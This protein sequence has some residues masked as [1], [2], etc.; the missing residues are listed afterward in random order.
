MPIV[1]SIA[2]HD[3]VKATLKYI[4]NPEKTE[5]LF[6]CNSLNCFTNAEDAYLNMKYIYENYT[7]HKFNEPLPAVGKR[8]VKAIHY[9]QSFKPD[10]N[11]T[12][13][14]VHR[15]GCAFIRKAFG[16][17]VQAVIATHV[18]K[19][20]Y[21]NHVLICTYG[22]DGHKFNDNYTTRRAI[23]EH[24]DRV[25]LAFGVPYI[26]PKH[27]RGMSYGEWLHHKRGTSWKEK[28]R[29]E[30]DT[31]VMT[32]KN[33]DELAATLEQRGYAIRYGERPAIKAPGQ[34]RFVCFKTLGDD[35]TIANINTRILWRDD[36]GNASREDAYN[37]GQVLT[38]CFAG[39]IA[40][41]AK[42]IVE[43]KKREVKRDEELPY[44]PH[45]DR[46][47]FQLGAQLAL[48]NKLNI[49]SIGEL[50]AKMKEAQTA[51]DSAV[52]EFNAISE[53]YHRLDDLLIQYD[54]YCALEN[55]P[56]KSLA[57]KMKLQ[58]AKQS[59][60]RHGIKT[61][62]DAR[63]LELQKQDYDNRIAELKEKMQTNTNLLSAY[64]EIIDTYNGISKGDYITHLMKSE[65]E[66]ETERR[67]SAQERSVPKHDTSAP[68]PIV[69]D[70]APKPKQQ[71]SV[72]EKSEPK[73]DES[74]Q[75]S[76]VP[77]KSRGRG[78]GRG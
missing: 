31:L 64:R 53:E 7:H 72:Q 40:Q 13:E 63:K 39:I 27:K 50:E 52:K 58:L 2:I 6:L 65:E 9:I 34:Q 55:K 37:K 12:P 74:S 4:L 36:L 71:E 20:H 66:L 23:R 59:L 5:G 22:I 75:K 28:I 1:K 38:I 51:Y 73:P 68:K 62:E 76:T 19:A 77:H 46:D 61:L 26:E 54:N 42:R 25:C 29:R 41:L 24:S 57:E 70:T 43:G 10:S 3:N 15:M 44:L 47:V 69:L 11:L 8:R 49:H 48:I 35:Y 78:R 17:N 14:L 30:I 56:N 67:D 33:F 32:S 16:D 21:H 45:N 18:D 60:A